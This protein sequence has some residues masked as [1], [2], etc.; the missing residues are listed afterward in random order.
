MLPR[1]TWRLYSRRGL[2]AAQVSDSRPIKWADSA[3]KS[4]PFSGGRAADD[5]AQQA[6]NRAVSMTFGEN[7]AKITPQIMAQAKT[8]IGG[9]FN[10]VAARTSIPLDNELQ[11]DLQDII[12]R[13]RLSMGADSVPVVERNA[14]N[15]LNTAAANGGNIGGR[16]YQDLTQHAGPL[17]T[18][19]S[20]NDGGLRN[21]GGQLRN[22]LDA[23][24]ARHAAPEDLAALQQ[25]RA[26]WR[27]MITVAPLTRRAD[28][29]G[30]ASPATG[31]I[32]PSQLQGVVNQKFGNAAY[33]LPGEVPLND[34]AKIGQRFF[35]ESPS[36][37]TSERNFFYR[38]LEH[39]ASG[40]A[41][42]AGLGLAEGGGISL[43]TALH[44]VAGAAAVPIAARIARAPLQSQWLADKM[45][46]PQQSPL[47]AAG[48]AAVPRA[49]GAA[50]V[51]LQGQQDPSLA[52]PG[53]SINPATGLPQFNLSDA[54]REAQQHRRTLTQDIAKRVL[55]GDLCEHEALVQWVQQNK[56]DLRQTFGGQGLQN[57]VRAAALERHARFEKSPSTLFA[58]LTKAP[59]PAA[60]KQALARAGAH[61]TTGILA[62]AMA[63]QPLTTALATRISSGKLTKAGENRII[64][65]LQEGTG[66]P[67]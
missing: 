14:E 4:V 65:A 51:Q 27:N 43:M 28:V 24:L 15:I 57:I 44:G 2:T 56:R 37:G 59:P 12:D 31:D 9:V 55:S 53:P 19:M 23:A 47:A 39:V 38:L 42:G 49:A 34:L 16:A 1:R 62:L 60:V 46:Q 29:V 40:A 52:P 26:Q 67:H 41:G 33:A 17:D 5:E 32:I 61:D 22:A 6:F 18:L 25:A 8:R 20:G 63:S 66:A 58:A 10:D 48:R 3:L 13:A 54:Q 50:A 36:S 7:A 11:T 35:K 21:A 64:R 30:G 45:L